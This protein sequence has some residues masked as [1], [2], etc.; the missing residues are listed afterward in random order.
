MNI[1]KKSPNE[2]SIYI[3]QFNSYSWS[4]FTNE[5]LKDQNVTFAGYSC[6]HP[7]ESKM[8]VTVITS[9][10]NPREVITN[11]FNNLISK[12]DELDIAVKSFKSSE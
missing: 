5:L 2:S 7:L 9:D 6:P 1:D 12:L 4:T 8:I 11:T 10:K 3:P